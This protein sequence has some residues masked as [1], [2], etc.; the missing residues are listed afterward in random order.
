MIRLFE[1]T[2]RRLFLLRDIS[3]TGKTVASN[4]RLGKGG[5]VT[6]KQRRIV[7]CPRVASVKEIQSLNKLTF[8][9]LRSRFALLV[10][11]KLFSFA[12]IYLNVSIS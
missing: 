6:C 1:G 3:A 10:F 12:S 2:L 5:A 7:T 4:E 9:S 11:F 8:N